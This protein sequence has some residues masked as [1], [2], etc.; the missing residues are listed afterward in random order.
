MF[1]VA[2][3][4]LHWYGLAYLVAFLTAPPLMRAAIRKWQLPVDIVR[5][6][7]LCVYLIL[8][9]MLGGRLGEAL[10]YNHY[11]LH[12]VRFFEIWRGGMSSH[13]GIAGV[14]IATWFFARKSRQSV[15]ALGDVV[16]LVA[17]FGLFLGR[18]G[19]F[20]NSEMIGAVTTVPWAIIYPVVDNLPR[21]P[22]QLYQALLEGP[23]LFAIMALVGSKVRRP[24][25][26]T[27][28]FFAA[29]ALLRVFSETFRQ[30]NAAYLGDHGGWTDGQ[31]LSG[32][33]LVLATVLGALILRAP[34]LR[35]TP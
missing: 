18:L 7:E 2:G 27:T 30:T 9:V 12:P 10:F 16:C 11:W 26:F 6:D 15:L 21:H 3:F 31:I 17:P 28:V 14:T 4:P 35:Q 13:G 1:T 20:V 19:N 23:V 25:G 8:G 29:Y 32:V 34:S 5:M 33:M 24:G 22:V